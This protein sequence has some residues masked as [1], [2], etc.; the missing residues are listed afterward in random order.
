M[1]LRSRQK[2]MEINRSI[3]CMYAST[4]TLHDYEHFFSKASLQR[5]P[6]A[7]RAL[8]P[9]LKIPGMISLGGG[10]PNSETFPFDQIEIHTTMVKKSSK[11]NRKTLEEVLQYS[12][13]LGLPSLIEQLE[14][15]QSTYHPSEHSKNSSILVGTGSQ[16]V[17]TKS[18]EMLLNPGDSLLLE[19]PTYSGSLAFLT[20]YGIN[21]IGIDTDENGL[22]PDILDE[23]LKN[24]N[25]LYPSKRKP[26]VLCMFY[27]FFNFFFPKYFFYTKFSTLSS[28]R[29]EK[30]YEIA[31]RENLIIL[32]DDPYFYLQF[33]P[34]PSN[35][36]PN[37]NETRNMKSFYSM[38]IDQRVIRFD[39]F[40]KV[41]SSGIRVGWAT[42][43]SQLIDRLQLHVRSTS[44]HSSGV[45][46]GL[47]AGLLK[48][49]GINGFS[50][51][52]CSHFNTFIN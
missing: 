42:G 33:N 21:Q 27:F 18:F 39:S 50:E 36:N 16:D 30:I 38:D 51:H 14:I 5:K 35:E 49:W 7:I 37:P 13:T 22:Q 25:V 11:T 17:L 26:R 9:L 52:V 41:L 44:L 28:Q 29:R 15:I 6:S 4:T 34:N 12:P 23:V 45:S 40:S 31:R 3:R 46:Q 48:M 20:P 47:V 1:I 2:C 24:W 8:Q 10:M 19:T 32:E 43:P